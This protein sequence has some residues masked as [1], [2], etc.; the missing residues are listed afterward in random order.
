[1]ETEPEVLETEAILKAGKHV[2]HVANNGVDGST[3]GARLDPCRSIGQAIANASEDDTILVGPGRY[4]DLNGNGALGELGEEPGTDCACVVNANKRLRIVSRDGA[5]VTVLDAGGA[6]A[7]VNISANGVVFGGPSRGFTVTKATIG[8]VGIRTSRNVSVIGNILRNN[9]GG[10]FNE[11][12]F[13]SGR[14]RRG[15]DHRIMGN[16][17]VDNSSEGIRTCGTG[18]LVR[19]NVAI[20]NGREGFAIDGVQ[21]VFANT[22]VGNFRGFVLSSVNGTVFT[23]NAALGNSAGGVV[24]T[25]PPTAL[26]KIHGNNFYGN[27]PE[28]GRGPGSCGLLNGSSETVHATNNYWGAATGPGSDP[29]DDVCGPSPT[30]SEPFATHEFRIPQPKR[31]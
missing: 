24:M 21:R 31:W 28:P 30:L 19:A 15:F 8:A 7:G 12:E 18:H 6:I 13:S 29:A 4:G 22:S 23:K 1:L 10:L 2:L 14:W 20:N 25:G 9:E 3:C 27:G 26:L 5:A 16:M 17:A 11:C